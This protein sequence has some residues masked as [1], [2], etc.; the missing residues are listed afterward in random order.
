[1]VYVEP[2]FAA[3]R[4]CEREG[5]TV[6][7]QLWKIGDAYRLKFLECDRYWR[8]VVE[9]PYDGDLLSFKTEHPQL[10]CGR[11]DGDSRTADR[12]RV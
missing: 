11:R 10:L 3:E 6:T 7:V 9:Q 12:P 1:M 5:R 8:H 4:N 2:E